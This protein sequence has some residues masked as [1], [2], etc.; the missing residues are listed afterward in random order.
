MESYWCHDEFNGFNA[1]KVNYIIYCWSTLLVLWIIDWYKYLQ[2]E[3]WKKKSS[4]C[5]GSY[6]WDSRVLRS[7]L[8]LV[9]DSNNGVRPCA[10]SSSCLNR[11][12]SDITAGGSMWCRNPGMQHRLPSHQRGLERCACAGTEQVR[13]DC[14]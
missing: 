14:P 5:S 10:F 1:D 2:N 13:D 8:S 12:N 9:R 7:V 4:I 6:L 3:S 11:G